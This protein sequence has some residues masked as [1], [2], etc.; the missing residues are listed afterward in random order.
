MKNFAFIPFGN[1][2]LVRIDEEIEDH[3]VH[4]LEAEITKVI[5]SK[6]IKGIVFNLSGVEVI[7]SFLAKHINKLSSTIK[8]L[9]AQPVI[10]GLSAPVIFTLIDFDI[11]FKDI[12][13]AFDIE[14]AIL[15]ISNFN[16]KRELID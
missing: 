9:G 6:K 16:N 5:T 3:Q 7:D 10:V 4:L 2:L 13:F 14:G 15:K 12:Q 1:I 8:I 11:H